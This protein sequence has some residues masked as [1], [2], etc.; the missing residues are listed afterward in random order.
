MQICTSVI[1]NSGHEIDL[2][3]DINYNINGS[4]HPATYYQPEEY[5]ELEIVDVKFSLD[6]DHGFQLTSDLIK[7]IESIIDLDLIEE[8]VWYELAKSGDE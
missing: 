4:Y 5:P 3:L 7:E 8:A 2:I 1:L 6:G